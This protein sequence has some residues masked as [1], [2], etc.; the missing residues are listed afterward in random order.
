VLVAARFAGDR[1]KAYLWLFATTDWGKGILLGAL[2]QLGLVVN[3]HV[4]EVEAMFE[5]KPVGRSPLDFKR[6]FVLAI[7]E[8]KTVKAELKQLQSII[9]LAPKNQL[10]SSVEVFTKLFLSAES[11]ASLVGENGVEDQF[12]NRMSIFR[13]HGS[14]EDRPLFIKVGKDAYR[15]AMAS[16][17][18]EKI[19]QAVARLRPMGRE[20][21][22]R[23]ADEAVTKFH[24]THGLDTVYERFSESLPDLV[25]QLKAWIDKNPLNTVN[26]RGGIYLPKPNL[27]IDEFINNNLTQSEAGAMRRKKTEIIDLI[28]FDGKGVNT[29][30]I[31]GPT[32]AVRLA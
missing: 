24:R 15:N 18:A 8:F 12:A 23:W 7:D 32:R 22:T 20:E 29:C 14:I 4:K 13:E 19:N 26:F 21:A 25:G 27:I 2:S 3:L 28:S 16:Y 6:A 10:T 9:E 31:P 17:I 5:G 11:V 1:K 30:R